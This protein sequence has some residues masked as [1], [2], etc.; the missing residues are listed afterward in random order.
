MVLLAQGVPFI[1]MG[2]EFYRTKQ[3]EENSYKSSDAI[4]RIDW[5]LIDKHQADIQKFKTLIRLR[6]SLTCLRLPTASAIKKNGFVS[7]SEHGT[8]VLEVCRDKSHTIVI[9]KPRNET[10][11]LSF[12]DPFTMLYSSRAHEDRQGIRTLTLDAVSVTV[13]V[14][15]KKESENHG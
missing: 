5:S 3:G 13:L 15:S 1:H 4:N 9:F 11:T 14:K 6:K 7:S 2:Q 8:T 10:E 12:D